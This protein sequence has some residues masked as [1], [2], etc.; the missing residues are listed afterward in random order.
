MGG[1]TSTVR[2]VGKVTVANRPASSGWCGREA[3]MKMRARRVP[4]ANSAVGGW[5]PIRHHRLTPPPGDTEPGPSQADESRPGRPPVVC[6]REPI[7]GR[8]TGG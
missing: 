4:G 2:A 7:D 5:L 8:V 1:A 6:R 3:T